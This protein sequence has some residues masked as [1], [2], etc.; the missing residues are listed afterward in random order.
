M[1]AALDQLIQRVREALPQP[2][3]IQNLQAHCETGVVTFLWDHHS[4]VVRLSRQVLELR[5]KNLYI[6]GP[7]LLM[8]AALRSENKHEQIVQTAAEMLRQA[9]ELIGN[10]A[11]VDA[12]MQLVQT[13]KNTLQRLAGKSW[14]VA[15]DPKTR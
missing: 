1:T 13:V 14:P 2:E 10:R 3:R 5:G 12:G 8:E 4:F 9:A 7:A 15:L 11:Q 6:T